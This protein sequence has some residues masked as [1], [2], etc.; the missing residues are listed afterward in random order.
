MADFALRPARADDARAM[1]EVFAAV[2]AER[3]GIATKPPVAGG[4]DL[5]RFLG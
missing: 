3:D 5:G 1:A 4:D 2:A